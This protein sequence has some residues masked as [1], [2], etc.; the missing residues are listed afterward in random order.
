MRIAN[1][2]GSLVLIVGLLSVP[3]PAGA[4]PTP[5]VGFAVSVR[6]AP[7]ILP[8]YLQPLCPGPGYI[9]EPGYWAYGDD[10]Y[11]W[12]PGIW[13]FPPR[14]GLLWTPGYWGFSEGIYLWHAGYWGLSVGFYGGI[15]YGFGYPGR[16]FYGGYWRGG[17]YFYNTR[18][19]NVDRTIVHNVYNQNMVNDRASN[20]VSFNGPHG[21]NAR[22]TSAELSAARQGHVSMTSA[23]IQ[24]QQ[25]ASTNKTLLASVNHGRPD[26]AAAAPPHKL[27]N[28]R[29]ASNENRVANAEG[30]AAKNRTAPAQPER[31]PVRKTASAT[32]PAP[33]RSERP[34]AHQ[35]VS[36]HSSTPASHPDN[37]PA[38]RPTASAP[39]PS[40]THTERP[41]VHQP[42]PRLPAQQHA[43]AP[44]ASAPHPTTNE[45][46][47]ANNKKPQHLDH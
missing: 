42:P 31:P 24:H 8:V 46:S 45:Q 22:P 3:F 4:S 2:I 23:Q 30:P 38:H 43:V 25:G 39:K 16:G 11:Y 9:W 27:S 5:T 35:A 29:E 21:V 7:P 20:R 40:A 33:A 37:A 18:V 17:Q 32:K 41:A 15:D 12:V 14:V 10:G 19:T 47:H 44:H 13:V 36:T 26:V 28:R 6:I 1:L 34:S